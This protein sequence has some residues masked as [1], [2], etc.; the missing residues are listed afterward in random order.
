MNLKQFNGGAIGMNWFFGVSILSG[1]LCA[2]I[3]LANPSIEST[4]SRARV[5]AANDEG[6]YEDEMMDNVALWRVAFA[7]ARIVAREARALWTANVSLKIQRMRPRE[8]AA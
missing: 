4:W 3:I 7:Y 6:W 5:R 2:T 1:L 8:H